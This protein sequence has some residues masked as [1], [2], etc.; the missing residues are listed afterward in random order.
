MNILEVKSMTNA[1]IDRFELELVLNVVYNQH[2]YDFRNYARA[3]LMRRIKKFTHDY[4]L[5]HISELVPLLIHN[6]K[7]LD[8]LLSYFSIT[9][10]EMFRDSSF[11]ISMK[12]NI[13]PYLKT[14]P[15]LKIWHAGCATGEEVYSMAILLKEEGLLDRTTI[16]ATDMNEIAISKARAGVYNKQNFSVYQKN[17]LS[18]IGTKDLENYFIIEKERY[19]V[20][21][22]IK[23]KITFAN[24]NLVS[25]VSF[26]HMNLILC[27]NVLIYFNRQLQ[28]NVFCLFFKSLLENGY[29]AIGSKETI[30]FWSDKD[31]FIDIDK[32]NKIYQL[33]SLKED[34]K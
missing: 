11:W 6:Q 19:V 8:K 7:Y 22:D 17:Y 13:I 23:S 3:S 14:F 5:K 27:R 34:V 29:L 28:E 24:H 20:K 9:V 32:R 4:N 18:S 26:G 25:D 16:F 30:D 10:T 1:E 21:A 31:K 2:G 33:S 12:D 15:Y